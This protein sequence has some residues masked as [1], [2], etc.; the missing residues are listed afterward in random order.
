MVSS[1][2]LDTRTRF[3]YRNYPLLEV[4]E[5]RKEPQAQFWTGTLK[6]QHWVVQFPTVETETGRNKPPVEHTSKTLIS[7]GLHDEITVQNYPYRG[8]HVFLL[9]KRRRCTDNDPNGISYTEI[10]ILLQKGAVCLKRLRM[11]F[12]FCFLMNLALRL[13]ASVRLMEAT[14]VNRISEGAYTTETRKPL[15]EIGRDFLSKSLG[16][17]NLVA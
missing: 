8:R 2:T 4:I 7:I 6:W 11:S 17:P 5:G 10:G 14:F 1:R 16:I 12:V 13:A 9:S 15:W 3:N